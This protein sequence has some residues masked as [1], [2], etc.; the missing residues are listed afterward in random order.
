M[1]EI[2]KSD[3][4]AKCYIDKIESVQENQTHRILWDFEIETHHQIPARRPDL[5]IIDKKKKKK[6]KK[7]KRA[8]HE[9]KMKR[10][11]QEK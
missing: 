3:H 1:Q 9:V 5:V 8:D 2:E 10:K 11:P 7:K 6:K 4:T